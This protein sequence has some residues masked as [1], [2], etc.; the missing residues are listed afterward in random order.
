MT[1]SDYIHFYGSDQKQLFLI[2]RKAMDRDG[3]VISKLNEIL[4]F[5]QKKWKV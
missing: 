1:N 4:P 3:I 2:E 5:R